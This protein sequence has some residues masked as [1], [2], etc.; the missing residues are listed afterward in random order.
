MTKYVI[1]QCHVVTK[2]H[3]SVQANRVYISE[4]WRKFR[5][6]TIS[7]VLRDAGS[8]LLYIW[9]RH[10]SEAHWS[11]NFSYSNRRRRPIEENSGCVVMCDVTKDREVDKN[12]NILK[13]SPL[14]VVSIFFIFLQVMRH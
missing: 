14:N 13:H 6:A 3:Q 7:R 2:V 4:A 12:L 11:R 8:Q 10:K 9:L 1:V 5:K